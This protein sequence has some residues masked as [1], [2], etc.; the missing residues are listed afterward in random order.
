MENFFVHM[1]YEKEDGNSYTI[2]YDNMSHDDFIELYG[3]ISDR[4]IYMKV[5]SMEDKPETI[6]YDVDFWIVDIVSM[7]K[8]GKKR[9]TKCQCR[10]L[11]DLSSMVLNY[12]APRGYIVIKWDIVR[13]EV[14]C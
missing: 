9:T 12:K 1:I 5:V 10:N 13:G 11:T 7:N 4:L 8:E 3:K 6:G 14:L 2:K